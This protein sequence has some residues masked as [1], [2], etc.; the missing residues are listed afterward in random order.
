MSIITINLTPKCS[1]SNGW[2][3]VVT[4]RFWLFTFKKKFF[5]CT[6]CE[7]LIP[8]EEAKELW[9]DLERQNERGSRA[10]SIKLDHNNIPE[11]VYNPEKVTNV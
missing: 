2:Y 10:G 11:S 7:D 9:N 3:K 6:D 4:F 5:L 1:H 8:I